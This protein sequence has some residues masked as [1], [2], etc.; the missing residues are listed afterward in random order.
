[1]CKWFVAVTLVIVSAWSRPA[2]A[3]IVNVQGQLAKPPAT[4]GAR[5]QLELALNWREGNN[6]I[7]EG[8]AAGAVL[9]REGRGLYLLIARGEYGESRGVTLARKTFEH[10]RARVSI[11][12]PWKWEAF[13]QH[14]YDAFRRLSVRGVAGTGPAYQIVDEKTVTMLAGA[15]VMAEYEALDDRAGTID[16]GETSL[17]ARASLYVTGTESI[18]EGVSIVETVY[19]Q[20][21][22]DE[23]G[24]VRLLGELAVTSKLSK[25]VALTDG[26]T[27]AYDRTPPDGIKTYDTQ[28]KVGVIVTF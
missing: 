22:L 20:P 8:A 10:L 24:D 6:P 26:L 1:M 18:G 13:L 27:V 9:V 28:L 14:E 17:V 23:P 2:S 3:Q 15:A 19:V 12:G 25:R 21:R 4:D 11:D 7:F 5:A 16:A